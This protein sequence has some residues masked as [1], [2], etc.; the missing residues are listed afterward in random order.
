MTLLQIMLPHDQGYEMI[1]K[2]LELD[3]VHYVDLNKNVM[4]NKLPFTELLKRAEETSKKISAIEQI[5][6]DY[7]VQ[8]RAPAD[9]ERLNGAIEDILTQNNA[10]ASKLLS[11]IDQDVH[12]QA[13]FLKT[14]NSLLLR[15]CQDFRKVI[16]RI[17][18][19]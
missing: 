13:D 12:E 8:L 17:F 7:S 10:A 15:S 14:Q 1:S 18:F 9:I 6:A 5:Y 4:P 16:A 3:I 2:L 19:L 11:Q